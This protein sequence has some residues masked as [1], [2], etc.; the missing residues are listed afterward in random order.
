MDL[1][2]QMQGSS[3]IYMSDGERGMLSAYIGRH[4]DVCLVYFLR[5]VRRVI[6]PC[7]TQVAAFLV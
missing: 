2:Q 7:A 6:V 3:N 4:I 1:R 5:R